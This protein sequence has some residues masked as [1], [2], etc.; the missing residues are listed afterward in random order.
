[1]EALS[2]AKAVRSSRTGLLYGGVL[3][4]HVSAMRS[5]ASA[6]LTRMLAGTEDAAGEGAMG[7]G[8]ME[9]DEGAGGDGRAA[10]TEPALEGFCVDCKEQEAAVRCVECGDVYCQICFSMLHRKGARA[11]HTAVALPGATAR[12]R[13]APA[14]ESEHMAVDDMLERSQ[15][16]AAGADVQPGWW[17]EERAKYIPM[18][19]TMDERKMLRLVEAALQVGRCHL[20]RRAAWHQF[21]KGG[22]RDGGSACVHACECVRTSW[23]G[24]T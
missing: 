1:M 6:R 7:E 19:L 23:C 24:Q 10:E 17:F 18:R 14:A 12:A 8:G 21:G 20:C 5:A 4:G 3:R 13:A 9:L 22:G 15:Q 2:A 11:R 16:P